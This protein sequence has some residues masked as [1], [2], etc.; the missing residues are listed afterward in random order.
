MFFAGGLRACPCLTAGGGVVYRPLHCHCTLAA[1]L[2]HTRCSVTARPLQSCCT[3]VA[4][5]LHPRLQC[6]CIPVCS[7]AA[8][9]L[10]QVCNK[11]AATLQRAYSNRAQSLHPRRC[12]HLPVRMPVV[13]KKTGSR[14]VTNFL[15]CEYFRRA[16]LI[17]CLPV[18]VPYLLRH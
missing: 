17:R 6:C 5:L 7:V 11:L 10:Q 9:G 13:H 14:F 12:L 18:P 16:S 1:A 15:F 4:A 3:P 8:T 2:L